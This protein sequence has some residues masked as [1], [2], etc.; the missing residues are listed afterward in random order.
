MVVVPSSARLLAIHARYRL[1]RFGNRPRG[2][3]PEANELIRVDAVRKDAR[4]RIWP[5]ATAI[6]AAALGIFFIPMG[7]TDSNVDDR[8]FWLLAGPGCVAVSVWVFVR[9]IRVR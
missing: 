2:L 8:P 1:R 4:S 6:L 5:V 3:L 7:F 9:W